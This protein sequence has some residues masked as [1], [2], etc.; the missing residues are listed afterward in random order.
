MK[1]LQNA[2]L[3]AL[4][5]R[6]THFSKAFFAAVLRFALKFSV[7]QDLPPKLLNLAGK[8]IYF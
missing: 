8:S 5:L 2:E 1:G 3:Q 4:F 6:V 7:S